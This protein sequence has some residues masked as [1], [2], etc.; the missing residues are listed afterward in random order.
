V[1]SFWE[2]HASVLKSMNK[3]GDFDVGSRN[4]EATT[5]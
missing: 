4:I 3:G 2:M 1:I 5:L